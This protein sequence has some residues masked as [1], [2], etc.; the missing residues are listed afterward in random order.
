MVLGLIGLHLKRA[1]AEGEGPFTRRRFGMACFW[2]GQALLASGLLLLL[3]G[4]LAGWLH[5]PFLQDL[6][7]MTA[8]DISA[9]STSCITAR[10]ISRRPSGLYARSR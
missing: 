5:G 1:F 9:S 6:G 7:L 10:T 8:P 4:Q 3:G 2:S